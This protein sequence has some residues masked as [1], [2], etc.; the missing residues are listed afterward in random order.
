MDVFFAFIKN[1]AEAEAKAKENK[2]LSRRSGILLR[3]MA[4]Q[5]RAK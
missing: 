4:K 3:L 5:L 1:K 2:I